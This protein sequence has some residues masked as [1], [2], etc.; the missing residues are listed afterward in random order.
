MPVTFNQKA[1]HGQRYTI[2]RED[3]STAF[4]PS[5]TEVLSVV[6][7]GDALS[8]WIAN[9]ERDAVVE[10][11]AGLYK[12]ICNLPKPIDQATFIASLQGRIGKVKAWRRELDKAAEIG[13][14]AHK[15]IEWHTRKMMGVSA[16][17]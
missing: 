10:A 7:K 1:K 16:G 4:L 3:G 15:L 5:V 8:N 13:T 14:N 17:K 11:A 9:Q 6:A 12:D 2:E